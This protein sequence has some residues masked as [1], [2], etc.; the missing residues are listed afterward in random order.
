M[1]LVFRVNAVR[2]LA[3]RGV[4]N[5]WLGMRYYSTPIQESEKEKIE[6]AEAGEI[7]EKKENTV[8]STMPKKT[9]NQRPAI[10]KVGVPFDPYIPP[11]WSRMPNLFLHP[12]LFGKCLFRRVYMKC[13]DWVQVF[14]FRR[15]MG[16]GYK[17]M[18]LKWKN[19]AI[20]DYVRINKAFSAR[21]LESTRDLMAEYVFFALGR[22][23]KQLP[24]DTTLGWELVK[25]NK[26]PKLMTFHSF[27]HEDGSVL[28]AQI[29]YR[30]DTKQRMTIK[31]RGSKEIQ[32]KTRDLIEYLAFNVDPYSDRVVIAGSLF[33][34]SPK[35]RFA[36]NGMPTRQE[37]INH[38]IKNGDIYRPEP[39]EEQKEK[40]DKEAVKEA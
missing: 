31:K 21:K 16:Q 3:S 26:A 33:E 29:V 8:N 38:M 39:T 4:S 14:Q 18:F 11:R 13:Y 32:E 36:A 30:F 1:S 7:A 19:D 6:A 27:P 37:T 24:K 9:E 25:F 10:T 15:S 28:L 12:L 34:S 23:Q 40:D 2:S 17:P 35:K 20:E 5:R 22:R